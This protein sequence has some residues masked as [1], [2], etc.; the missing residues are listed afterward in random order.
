MSAV[1]FYTIGLPG[2]GKTTFAAS[3]SFWLQV[4]HLRGDRIGLELFRFPTFSPQERQMVYA[5]MGRRAEESLRS[6][7]HIVYDAAVNTKAQ[8]DQLRALAEQC[9]AEAIG[10]CIVVPAQLAKNR[11]GKLRNDGIGP[12]SRIIPP[13]IFD[14]YL[15][16]F[17]VPT[18]EQDV[19]RVS[20]DASFTLQYRRLQR[21]LRRKDLAPIISG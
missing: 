7:R 5:E 12:V 17:E 1:L 4:P 15:A 2:S 21:Q 18:H 9:S 6:G 13:H 16:A 11:A 10:V 3:L 19:I 8:R 20:G 14:Q